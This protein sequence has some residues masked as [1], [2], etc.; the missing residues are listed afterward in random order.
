[1]LARRPTQVIFQRFPSL[2][3]SKHNVISITEIL[4]SKNPSN[5]SIEL[6]TIEFELFLTSFWLL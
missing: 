6:K 3:L 4:L 1:M 2:Y 5:F